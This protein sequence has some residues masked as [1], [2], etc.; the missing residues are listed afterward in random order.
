M[1]DHLRERGSPTQR[2]RPFPRRAKQRR[3]YLREHGRLQL[4]AA[5][6]LSRILGVQLSRNQ[7]GS[8]RCTSSPFTGGFPDNFAEAADAFEDGEVGRTLSPGLFR[9][10]AK[11]RSRQA[12]L[13]ARDQ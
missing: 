8:T 5:K 9:G 4:P 10:R 2:N 1:S 11:A 6:R 13:H 3:T 12:L 7:L